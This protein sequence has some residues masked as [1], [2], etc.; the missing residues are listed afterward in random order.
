M[1]FLFKQC[2]FWALVSLWSIPASAA[3]NQYLCRYDNTSEFGEQFEFE[4]DQKRNLILILDHRIGGYKNYFTLGHV[5]VEGGALNFHFEMWDSGSVLIRMSHNLDLETLRLKSSKAVYGSDGKFTKAGPSATAICNGGANSQPAENNKTVSISAPEP[6]QSQTFD[7]SKFVCHT[8]KFPVSSVGGAG[9]RTGTW[10]ILSMLPG[11]KEH[12]Y[13]PEN[14][15]KKPGAWCEGAPEQGI[16]TAVEV[17]YQPSSAD[18]TLH[19]FDRLLIANGYDKT[20]QTF[21]QNSRVKQIEIKTDDGRSWVRTLR[22][23]TGVQKVE[24]GETIRPHGL[25]VTI[26]D[27]YPGQKYEDTCLSYLMADISK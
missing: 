1:Q 9:E 11:S 7:E 24:L 15:S 8:E 22:D 26:L 10:C 23:E 18:G 13:G 5:E 6:A 3:E 2:L 27:V 16:G 19:E 25:L 21:M 4:Y 14:L 17:S 20:T 12:S